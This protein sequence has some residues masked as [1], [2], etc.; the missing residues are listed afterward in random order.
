[1]QGGPSRG[2]RQSRG[3]ACVDRRLAGLCVA[4]NGIDCPL[5]GDTFRFV[6]VNRGADHRNSH[7]CNGPQACADKNLD[8]IDTPFGRAERA[9][10]H[11][12]EEQ[13]TRRTKP[14]RVHGVHDRDRD[15]RQSEDDG[16]LVGDAAGGMGADDGAEHCDKK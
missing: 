5:H 13:G 16:H 15:G 1:M 9:A 6:K 14:K 11:Q 4:V 8:R 7:R 10:A 2:D 12:H 3:V